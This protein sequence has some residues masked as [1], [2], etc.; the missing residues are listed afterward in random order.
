MRGDRRQSGGAHRHDAEGFW[1]DIVDGF[2]GNPVMD[3]HIDVPDRS[4]FRVNFI[5]EAAKAHLCPEDASF[6]D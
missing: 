1:Y 3:G 6:F 5:P 2:D 4:G